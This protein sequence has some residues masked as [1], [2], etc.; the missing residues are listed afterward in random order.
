M[1]YEHSAQSQEF[2]RVSPSFQLNTFGEPSR[3]LRDSPL[4][5]AWFCS[6][7]PPNK[8]AVPRWVGF[9]CDRLIRS[10]TSARLRLQLHNQSNHRHLCQAVGTQHGTQLHSLTGE[11]PCLQSPPV[12]SMTVKVAATSPR[13]SKLFIRR[14]HQFPLSDTWCQPVLSAFHQG[15]SVLACPSTAW[16]HFKALGKITQGCTVRQHLLWWPF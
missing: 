15:V 1:S 9:H 10:L 8:L 16:Q 14:T 5:P 11:C 2:Y 13:V 7:E 12:T 3:P 6:Q 4:L